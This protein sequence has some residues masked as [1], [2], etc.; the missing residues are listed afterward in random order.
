MIA[1]IILNQLPPSITAITRNRQPRDLISSWL[2]VTRRLKIQNAYPRRPITNKSLAKN[3]QII[4]FFS[5][6]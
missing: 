1:P 6:S 4:T 5:Y 2:Y 3:D